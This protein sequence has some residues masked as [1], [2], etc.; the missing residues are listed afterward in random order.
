MKIISFD[1]G[2]RNT[3]IC[4]EEY[5]QTIAEQ[6]EFP[7]KANRYN[8]DGSATQEMQ[9]SILQMV[10]LGEI[11]LLD[12][13]DLG[14]KVDYFS[15]DAFLN[16]FEWLE[17]LHTQKYFENVHVVLLEQQLLKT[18][19]IASAIMHNISAWFLIK[20]KKQFPVIFYPAKNKTRIIGQTLKKADGSNT[21]KYER[22]K[23]SWQQA[24]IYLIHRKDEKW[25]TFIF[26]NNKKKK[27]DLSD[28]VLMNLSYMIQQRIK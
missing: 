1:I 9:Q 15:H 23:W 7:A 17:S 16:L 12:K 3:S 22:K 25:H 10:N 4:I 14:E 13:K 18:N 28:V 11:V 26:K 8:K 27:D 20:F 5:D 21:T 6:I 24:E 2:L 19:F